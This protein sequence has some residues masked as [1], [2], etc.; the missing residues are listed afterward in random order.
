MFGF[1]FLFEIEGE[2]EEDANG[3]VGG[4]LAETLEPVVVVKI[5]LGID[6]DTMI[7]DDLDEVCFRLG[8]KFVIAYI[9]IQFHA[10][11]CADPVNIV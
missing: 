10:G 4:P 6:P 7:P 2:I 1:F 11:V 5:D 9:H 3:F 8:G